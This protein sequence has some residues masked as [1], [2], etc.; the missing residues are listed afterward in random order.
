MVL[1]TG[2]AVYA[3]PAVESDNVVRRATADD[4]VAEAL[5]DRLAST[6]EQAG[7]EFS[8]RRFFATTRPSGE[9]TLP[10]DQTH[11]SVVVGDAAVVKWMVEAGP[12][13]APVLVAQLAA[14]GFSEMP[15]PWGFVSWVGG[16]DDVV[17]AA[18]SDYLPGASDGW[19]WCVADV[20][21]FAVGQ[22]ELSAAL[23]PVTIL[24]GLVARMHLAL[25]TPSDVMPQPVERADA[26]MVASWRTRALSLLDDAIAS[27]S[28]AEGER[29]RR[30]GS[31]IREVLDDL[32]VAET[33]VMR[34]HGDLHVGQVL[35]W[36]GGYAVN[37]FDGNPVLSP[38]ERLL[39]SSPARDVAGMV[40]SLDH[41]GRVVIGR[42]ADADASR[43]GQ[44]IGAAQRAF[45]GAYREQLATANRSE[46]FDPRLLDAFR[47]EQECR[48]FLYA[49]R[50]LPRWRYVPDAA[51]AAMFP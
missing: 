30:R 35:R 38:A 31:R 18:V 8:W 5:L 6:G 11:D 12:T 49:E 28:G 48:E 16:D 13:P 19:S 2:T 50:H 33:P 22:E 9:R 7:A 15:R 40:Q 51:L 44:W 43:A 26:S 46:L 24:G 45:L 29:L 27:V 41:V 32:S 3:A 21:A 37:D 20:S 34:V 17:V 36:D 10:V 14:G 4:G 23:P 42:V 25:A 47:A 1:A 39:P